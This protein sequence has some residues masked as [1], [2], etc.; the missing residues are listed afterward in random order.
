M[1]FEQTRLG[2]VLL[3]ARLLGIKGD[4]S[5][6]KTA[7]ARDVLSQI[8]KFRTD[9]KNSMSSSY[10]ADIALRAVGK[11]P[12]SATDSMNELA[13]TPRGY[14]YYVISNVIF[15]KLVHG[16]HHIYR[17]TLSM[18]GTDLK[19]LYLKISAVLVEE[20]VFTYDDAIDELNEL[21]NA[22]QEAG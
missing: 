13:L 11:N 12:Q 17:G 15:S 10:V 9:N 1:L 21:N 5:P 18:M 2:I 16:E 7:N 3:V 4:A 19:A 20:G 14:A 8:E 22:I 6:S